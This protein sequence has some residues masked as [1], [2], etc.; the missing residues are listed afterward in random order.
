MPQ[1]HVHVTYINK[2]AVRRQNIY[3]VFYQYHTRSLWVRQDLQLHIQRLVSEAVAG[4]GGWQ[5]RSMSD[6]INRPGHSVALKREVVN[7]TIDILE[8]TQ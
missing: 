8:R 1:Q 5:G 7:S 6:L 2:A 3:T 4:T